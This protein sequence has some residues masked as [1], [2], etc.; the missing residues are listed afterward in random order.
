M[1]PVGERYDEMDPEDM[2]RMATL[3]CLEKRG[4]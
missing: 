1:G 4:F 3:V 2:R